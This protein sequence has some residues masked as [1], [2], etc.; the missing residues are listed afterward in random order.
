[1]ELRVVWDARAWAPPQSRRA[2]HDTET[3]KFR[4]NV[5]MRDWCDGIGM[6]LGVGVGFGVVIC[7]ST[8]PRAKSAWTD[9]LPLSAP[10]RVK[11]ARNARRLM[12]PIRA[13]CQRERDVLS[14][15]GLSAKNPTWK[16][17]GDTNNNNNLVNASCGLRV[18]NDNARWKER[19]I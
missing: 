13:L 18:D 16:T 1:M 4:N 3:A 19:A 12:G 10:E 5:V 7:V 11:C 15:A 2:L 6:A 14:H 8:L 9:Q 17:R